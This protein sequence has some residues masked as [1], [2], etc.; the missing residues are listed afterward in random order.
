LQTHDFSTCKALGFDIPGWIGISTAVIGIAFFMFRWLR[1]PVD[2]EDYK[3]AWR[4][5]RSRFH[6]LCAEIA[7]LMDENGRMFREFGPNSGRGDGLPKA[8][9]YNLSI[10]E[11][12]IP[13]IALNNST[14]KSLINSN[15]EA[16]PNRHRA[17]FREWV[18]HIDAFEAHSLD[19]AA[20][21][22]NNQFPS[23]VVNI[24]HKYAPN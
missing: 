17:M 9:R 10:W 20:D 14:I 15:F 23:G 11:Q 7:P 8:V 13:K 6:R 19:S 12:I 21:Y 4:P 16:I 3:I 24:V 5:W 2:A 1:R 22:R 18:Y